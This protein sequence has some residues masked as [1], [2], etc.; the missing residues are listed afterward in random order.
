MGGWN[1]ERDKY[2]SQTFQ[3]TERK[4]VG[5]NVIQVTEGLPMLRSSIRVA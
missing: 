1:G 5:A 3:A 2:G 4:K